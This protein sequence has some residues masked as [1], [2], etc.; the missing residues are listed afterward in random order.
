MKKNHFIFIWLLLLPFIL[1]AQMGHFPTTQMPNISNTLHGKPN[2]LQNAS[3]I[4][5]NKLEM[6]PSVIAHVFVLCVVLK[7]VQ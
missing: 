6:R 1:T 7:N 4:G 3:Y 2:Y 5:L